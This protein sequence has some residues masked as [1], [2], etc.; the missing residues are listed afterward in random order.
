M[1]DYGLEKHEEREA[2][3][4]QFIAAIEDAKRE[5]KRQASFKI[6]EFMAYKH[7]VSNYLLHNCVIIVC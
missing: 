7:S 3:M 2:E 1:F 6:D 5:N 4:Q